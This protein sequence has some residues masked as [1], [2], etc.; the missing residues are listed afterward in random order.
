MFRSDVL[1]DADQRRSST[2]C[3][4]LATLHTLLLASNGPSGRTALLWPDPQKEPQGSF[5]HDG[6]HVCISGRARVC[7]SC[8]PT[9]HVGHYGDHL[10]LTA[11][12]TYD[13]K[14]K[15]LLLHFVTFPDRFTGS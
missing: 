7:W 13:L 1:H 8:V 2:N 3:Y 11:N 14:T 10:Y 9:V 6:L 12:V 4:L 5:W 15:E